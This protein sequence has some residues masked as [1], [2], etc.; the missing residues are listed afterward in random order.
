MNFRFQVVNFG[1]KT[2][3]PGFQAVS[4]GLNVVD[5]FIPGCGFLISDYR[6]RVPGWEF[7]ISGSG[8]W[9]PGWEFLISGSELWIPG[10]ELLISGC[11][12]CILNM[13]MLSLS[14]IKSPLP[15]SLVYSILLGSQPLLLAVIFWLKFTLLHHVT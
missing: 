5:S 11:G 7:L 14:K 8:F 12:F 1:F 9:I 3:D 13:L 6:F 15:V 2:V 4:S 10:W